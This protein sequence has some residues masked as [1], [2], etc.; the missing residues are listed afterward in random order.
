MRASRSGTMK[1]GFCFGLAPACEGEPPAAF[2]AF[3]EIGEGASGIG[4]KHDA[5]SRD[6]EIGP[7]EREIEHGGVG[8]NEAD[9]QVLRGAL[10]RSGEHRLGNVEPED[11]AS[12]SHARGEV[13]RRRA[14]AA[15]DVDHPFAGL[16]SSRRHQPVGNRAQHLIL[17]LLMVD[18]ALPAGAAQYSAWA[19]L[20]A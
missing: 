15:A 1:K 2:E 16:G 14:A 12:R 3:A 11:L 20:S 4:E 7:S 6:D 18:P 5:E 13:D 17:M 9:R 10:A 19:A 8:V